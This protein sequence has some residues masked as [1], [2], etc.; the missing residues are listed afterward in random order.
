MIRNQSIICFA[1]EDWWYHHQHSKNHIMRRLARAGNRVIFVNSISMGLPSFGS[2]DLVS[3]IKRKLRSYAKPVRVTEEGII[4]VSPLVLPVYSNS[5]MRA[6][7]RWLLLMQMKLLMIAYDI[8]RPILWIAI[9]TAR[10]VVG[11]LGERALIYQVSDKYDANR[12]DHATD[13]NVIAEMHED[14]LA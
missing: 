12:M 2:P 13:S 14:L 3:K 4:V 7:N 5:S 10:E 1:G 11:R 6:I 8:R 9:P